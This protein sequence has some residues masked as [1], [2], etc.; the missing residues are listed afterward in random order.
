MT[1]SLDKILNISLSEYMSA[2]PLKDHLLYKLSAV[3]H[4]GS[5]IGEFAQKVPDEK[6]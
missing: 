6:P 4:Q 1:I 2:D 5:F 3:H